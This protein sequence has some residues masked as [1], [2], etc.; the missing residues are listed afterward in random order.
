[1]DVHAPPLGWLAS[2]SSEQCS[3]AKRR[4][5]ELPTKLRARWQACSFTQM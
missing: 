5:G 1:M 2:N 4:L 3:T